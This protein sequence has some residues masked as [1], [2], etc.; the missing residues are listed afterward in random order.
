MW[1]LLCRWCPFFIVF[2]VGS[3][4]RHCTGWQ[5]YRWPNTISYGI[6]SCSWSMSSKSVN[7]CFWYDNIHVFMCFESFS[8]FANFFTSLIFTDFEQIWI[9]LGYLIWLDVGVPYCCVFGLLIIIWSVRLLSF[10]Y[11]QRF[12]WI[13]SSILAQAAGSL[14]YLQTLICMKTFS[15]IGLGIMKCIDSIMIDAVPL[16]CSGPISLAISYQTWDVNLFIWCERPRFSFF[17]FFNFLSGIRNWGFAIWILICNERFF[18]AFVVILVGFLLEHL[19]TFCRIQCFGLF[20]HHNSIYG[21]L[22]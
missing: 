17:T 3:I 14:Q 7:I 12:F 13:L 15:A 20:F 19:N 2:Q 4:A 18:I 9:S 1:K 8:D 21:T 11:F 5:W 16:T 10:H 22:L 6:S